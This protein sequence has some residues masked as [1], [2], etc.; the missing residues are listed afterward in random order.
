MGALQTSEG[1]RL[2]R[3]GA[4]CVRSDSTFNKRKTPR[5]TRRKSRGSHAPADHTMGH[6][7]SRRRAHQNAD[8]LRPE[9]S[10]S[11][12]QPCGLKSHATPAHRNRTSTVAAVSNSIK[13][14]VGHHRERAKD[15]AIAKPLG[16]RP[17]V[18]VMVIWLV[19]VS[20]C[21]GVASEVRN[22]SHR[23]KE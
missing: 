2:P 6:E 12:R 1:A 4:S 14:N 22:Y 23:P 8:D 9:D 17:S 21:A 19:G 15:S 16:S 18:D 10:R 11:W 5:T 20:R 13:F 3:N 7:R